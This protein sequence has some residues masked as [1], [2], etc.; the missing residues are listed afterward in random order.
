MKAIDLRTG[1]PVDITAIDSPLVV[2]TAAGEVCAEP[3]GYL[4]ECPGCWPEVITAV[5]L[6]ANFQVQP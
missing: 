6:A 3:G 1:A 2:A 5:Q 4:V